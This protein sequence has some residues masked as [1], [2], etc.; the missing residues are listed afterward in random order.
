[1]MFSPKSFPA[2]AMRRSVS[3]RLFTTSSAAAHYAAYRPHQ[4]GIYRLPD[5]HNEPNPQ[6][7]PGSPER[8]KLLE[9]VHE[10]CSQAPLHVPLVIN[11]KEVKT[12]NIEQ[13]LMPAEHSKVLC[14]YENAGPKE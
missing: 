13:Q 8:E 2:S 4:L 11:G 5:I 1:M 9:A 12:G 7:A 6:Y 14:T 10:L 3:P